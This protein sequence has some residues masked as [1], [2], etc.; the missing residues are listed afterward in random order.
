[1]SWIVDRLKQFAEA[2]KAASL[3]KVDGSSAT[4]ILVKWLLTN[5]VTVA[6]TVSLGTLLLIEYNR[7]ASLKEDLLRNEIAELTKYIAKIKAEDKELLKQIEELSNLKNQNEKDTSKIRSSLT[8]TSS[9]E[10]RVK[11]LEYKNRLMKKRGF[12]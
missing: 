9:E 3:A 6:L 12:K 5:W 2:K 4:A 8:N 10:K 7:N 1:M 11:L